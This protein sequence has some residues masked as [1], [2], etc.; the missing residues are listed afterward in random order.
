MTFVPVDAPMPD[1]PA[2][3]GAVP[4]PVREWLHAI[5]QGADHRILL[6]ASRSRCQAAQP[7]AWIYPVDDDRFEA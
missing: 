3:H 5:A 1:S 2:S 7:A 4:A 6:R